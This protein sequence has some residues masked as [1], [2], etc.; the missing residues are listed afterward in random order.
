MKKLE[1][2]M[3]SRKSNYQASQFRIVRILKDRGVLSAIKED[4]DKSNTKNFARNNA[5]FTILALNIK[6]HK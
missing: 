2:S 4:L 3:A 6:T 1:G 5:A